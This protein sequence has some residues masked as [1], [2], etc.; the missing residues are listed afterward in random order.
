[1]QEWL[2]DRSRR[3]QLRRDGGHPRHV[4]PL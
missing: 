1:M 4:V 2:S 3:R